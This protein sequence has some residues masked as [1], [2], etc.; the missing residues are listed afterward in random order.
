MNRQTN[1]TKAV[2]VWIM[3]YRLLAMKRLRRMTTKSIRAGLKEGENVKEVVDIRG[4]EDRRVGD[5]GKE[6][7]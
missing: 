4:V 7:W 3:W 5:D 2:G 6:C 1:S